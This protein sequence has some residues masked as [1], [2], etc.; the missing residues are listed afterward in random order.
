MSEAREVAENL[1]I[2]LTLETS[3]THGVSMSIHKQLFVLLVTLAISSGAFAEAPAV[4]R[5]R[6]DIVSFHDDILTVHRRSGDTVSIKLKP[7]L[8]VSAL[9]SMKLSDVKVGTYVGLP[10]T[11]GSD[12][13]LTASAVLVFPEAARGTQE[14]HFPYDFGPSSTMTNANIDAIVTG[15]AGRDLKVSYKAGDN[16]ITVPDNAPIVTFA[17][18]TRADLTVGKK[19]VVVATPA[20]HGVFDAAVLFVEKDGVL[21]PL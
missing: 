1:L 11:A 7:D 20:E 16:T 4:Q 10:A 19:V 12:G 9:T 17:P 13:K 8:G 6:G 18:A 21:P 3:L 5:I 15:T 2:Q 14:G